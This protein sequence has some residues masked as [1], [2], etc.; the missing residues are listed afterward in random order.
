M[1]GPNLGIPKQGSPKRGQLIWTDFEPSRGH[2]QGGRRPA[3][4]ISDSHYNRVTR[5]MVCLAVTSRAKGYFTELPL[6]EGMKLRGVILTSHV[7]TLD[8]QDRGVEVIETVPP[9]ILED[10]VNRL[11]GLVSD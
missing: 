1:N 11:M 2:E 7:Y 6:P 8:W 10:A 5:L 3:V 9:E 4:V